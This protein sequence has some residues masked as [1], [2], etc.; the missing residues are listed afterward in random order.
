MVKNIVIGLLVIA[1]GYLA[2]TQYGGDL[3]SN[4]ALVP[5]TAT[6]TQS[7]DMEI[8]IQVVTSARNPMDGEIREFPTP[9]DV[10]D[11]WEEIQNDIPTL[12][13]QVQ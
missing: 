13:L 12:D 5:P 2:Y 9:C 11:G 7:E 4:D 3:W 8:C 1:V 6:S 10:P